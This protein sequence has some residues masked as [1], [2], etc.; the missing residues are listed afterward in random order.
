MNIRLKKLCEILTLTILI[1]YMLINMGMVFS[2]NVEN[3][4]I[5][6]F[7][8]RTPYNGRGVNVPSDSFSPG[9]V[10]ILFAFVTQSNVPLKGSLVTFSVKVPNGTSFS[11]ASETNSSGIAT[12]NFTISSIWS[13]VHGEWFASAK[14][15]INGRVFQDALTFKVDWIVKIISVRT[16]NENLSSQ[17]N[18]GINS[19]VGVEIA[20]R[21]IAMTMRSTS[22]AIVIKD[23]LD[24]V[25]GCREISDFKVQPNESKVFL[26][27][28]L[29][30]SKNGTHI[31]KAQVIVSALTEEG[32][33]YC[34]SVSTDF[35]ISPYGLQTISFHD[36]AVVVVIPSARRVEPGET[37]NIMA[38]VQNE[39]TEIESFNVSAYYDDICMGNLK[40]SS[41][42]PYSHKTLN[43]IFDTSKVSIGNYTIKVS[44][45]YMTDEVD[46]KTLQLFNYTDNIFVDGIIEVKPKP[47]IIHNI[48]IIDASIS[49]ETLYIGEPLYIKVTVLNKGNIAETFNVETFYNSSLIETLHVEALAPGSQVTLNFV[50]NTSMIHVGVYQIKAF[51]PLPE[52]NNPTDNTFNIGIVH[53][54]EKPH[55]TPQAHD[56]AIINVTSSSKTI[57]IGENLNI[58]VTVK[59]E[60]DYVESFTIT[61]FY[62]S[63]ILGKIF[64][65]KLQ[66]K[67]ERSFIIQWNTLY[68][69][70]GNYTLSAEASVVPGEINIENNKFTDG[71]IWVKQCAFLPP[72]CGIPPE[73]LTLIFLLLALIGSSITVT[74]IIILQSRKKREKKTQKESYSQSNTSRKIKADKSDNLK[75]TKTCSSCGKE[76]PATYTFCPYCFTFNGKD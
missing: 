69:A 52:D 44:I 57:C 6:L 66:P 23:E 70:A 51:V 76:F 5:D 15:L 63:N 53:I 32:N 21:S 34:P 41:L 75:R 22:I 25:V 18:F 61:A 46:F 72:I 28:K 67:N 40:V 19:D 4:K 20:L 49:N 73:T 64:V 56:I 60:G 54:I 68:V 7:T 12:V 38:V 13:E 2:F 37:V 3:G 8:Q 48:G 14:V 42:A 9:E 43:F 35:F 30:I 27:S 55:P 31:G 65:S 33:A 47:Q 36:V 1:S 62:G 29:H 10:V 16:I 59:N 26:Y 74:I 71:V 11:L 39:G 24:T 45:P 17:T 58:T 50:W